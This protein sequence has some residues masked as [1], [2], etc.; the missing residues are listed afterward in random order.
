MKELEKSLCQQS[1]TP[2][3]SDEEKRKKKRQRKKLMIIFYLAG[4]EE[5]NPAIKREKTYTR[6][7]LN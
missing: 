6:L 7:L 2:L 5:I 1:D 4:V 3:K